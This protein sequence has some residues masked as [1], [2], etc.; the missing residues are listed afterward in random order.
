[1]VLQMHTCRRVVLVSVDDADGQHEVCIAAVNL[2]SQV[3]RDR[4]V[5]VDSTANIY[6]FL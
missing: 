1:M 6:H 5:R 3:P 4:D 2:F